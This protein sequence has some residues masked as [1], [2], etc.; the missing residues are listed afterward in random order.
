MFT[1]KRL[2]KLSLSVL[3]LLCATAAGSARAQ[4]ESGVI[5]T[6]YP[7]KGDTAPAP[8]LRLFPPIG[9]G[10]YSNMGTDP[11]SVSAVERD[12]LIAQM[13][14]KGVIF[15]SLNR[16]E[17]AKEGQNAIQVINNVAIQGATYT[18]VLPPNWKRANKVPVVLSGNGAGTSNNARLWKG[19]GTELISAVSIGSAAGHSGLIAA[20]SNAG[21][22]ESQGVDDHTYKSV[23]VF[24]D[25]IA[26]NGGDPQRAITVGGSRGGGTA[27]MWAINPLNLNYTVLAV[28]ADIPPTAYGTISQQSVLTYPNLG[29]IGEG[30]THDPNAYQYGSPNGP[31]THL[32]ILF[33]SQDVATIDAHSP[34]GMADRLKGKTLVIGRGTHDAFFSLH[35]FLAFDHKLNDLAITHST[36]I[37]L[38]Q[39]HVGNKFLADQAYAYIDAFTQGKSYQ[40]PVGR[41]LYINLAPPDGSQVPLSE[42]LKNGLNADPKATP[43]AGLDLPFQA[44]I[45]AGAGVGLPVDLSF[46]GKVG[47]SFSYAAKDVSGSEWTSGSGTFDATECAHTTLKAPAVTGNYVWTFTYEGKPIPSNYTPLRNEGGCGQPAITVVTQ[48]QPTPAE[49]NGG[50]PSLSFG[51]DQYSA[52]DATCSAS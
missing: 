5:T 1:T 13:A 42:F 11:T 30:A 9:Y 17:D 28:F 12:A 47:S 6:N 26:Q 32:D 14:Q 49:L 40:P 10:D 44:E 43:T 45:P 33:G 15:V 38:G 3:I 52:Q 18:I 51:V 31:G 2:L 48:K 16:W 21:G 20:Y 4:Q 36:V 29:Y 50:A 39:G 19:S 27:L 22:T 41:F 24:F 35:E 37:T 34:I 25:F 8:A 46:C 23:G 7:A